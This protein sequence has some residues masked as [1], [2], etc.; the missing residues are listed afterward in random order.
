LSNVLASAV[1][2]APPAASRWSVGPPGGLF[3]L[4]TA[5]A[6]LIALDA[7]SRDS[8]WMLLITAILWLGL[9]ASWFARFLFAAHRTGLRLPA[10]LWVRWLAIPL[11]LV[12]VL[13]VTRTGVVKDARLAM[14]RGAMDSMASDVMAGGSTQR[15]WMGL[16]D[17]GDV[18]RTA[19]GV[20]FV[21][22]DSGLSRWG[23]AYASDGQPDF[24]PDAD[25]EG[26][27]WTGPTFESAE[28]G[29]WRWWQEWD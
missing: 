15:G 28:G 2:P 19:N 18:Q 17:V 3:Y 27:L 22:D 23:F 1:P 26:G 9:A 14:S 20:R 8:L 21:V 16:Y 24:I 12:L 5:V 25:E 6:I 10:A 7:N 13:A 29:W 11:V 4:A